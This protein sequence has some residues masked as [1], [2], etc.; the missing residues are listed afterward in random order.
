VPVFNLDDVSAIPFLDGISGVGEYQHRA[1]LRAL[2]GDLFAAGTPQTRGYE[3]YCHE[4]LGLGTVDFILAEAEQA[5]LAVAE[6]CSHGKAFRR[7]VARTRAFGG[8]VIHPYMGNE[9]VWNLAA[10]VAAETDCPVTV[11][12]PPPP[13]TWIANDKALFGEVVR[14]VLGPKWLVETFE[15]DSAESLARHLVDLATRHPR[16]ALKRLRCASAMGN[17]VFDSSRISSGG[18]RSAR[19]LVDSF[20]ERTE[21]PGNE[22]VQAVAWEP[23]DLSPSTQLWIP[24]D[25]HGEPRVDGIYEQ[26]LEGEERVFIGSRPSGLPS[27]VNQRLSEASLR[28]A[29]AL[30]A[31]GYAGRCSFD[32]LVVGDPDADFGIHFTECNGRWGGTSTP[33]ALL[34]RL[35]E[36]PRPPYRAQDFVRSGLIGARFEELLAATEPELYDPVT[37]Q[38]RLVFYNVGPLAGAGKIDVIALG[39][40]REEADEMII[41]RLPSLLGV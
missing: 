32:F 11:I 13:V 12:A 15:T 35:V 8:L 22:R 37:G 19:R 25:G 26:I 34:D 23:T 2:E 3:R 39:R 41:E 16:I 31:L 40:T 6:A 20:L 18:F 4:R 21:W 27:T 24:P 33:M 5:P 36:G 10:R 17:E 29:I 38:G 14:R 28:V 7:L 30:Q 9:A 1:R